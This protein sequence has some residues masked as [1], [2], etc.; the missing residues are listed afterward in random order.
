MGK[1]QRFFDA[2]LAAHERIDDASEQPS[3]FQEI[4]SSVRRPSV[5]LFF[6]FFYF[7][8]YFTTECKYDH[9]PS[10]FHS[11][12]RTFFFSLIFLIFAKIYCCFSR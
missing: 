2:Y 8:I 12:S 9:F 11:S 6:L 10:C 5:P 4:S 3:L 7:M 1:W